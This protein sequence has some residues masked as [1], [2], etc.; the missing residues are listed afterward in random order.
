MRKLFLIFVAGLALL[1]QTAP[2]PPSKHERDLQFEAKKAAPAKATVAPVIPHSYAL[3]VGIAQYQNLPAAAQLKYPERDAEAIYSILISPEGGNF[4]AEN[5]HILSGPKATLA[6]VRKEL[7]EWL[8]SVTKDDDRVLIYFAGH[9]FVK[10][11][12]AY[13]APYDIKPDD[14]PATGYPMDQLGEVF[15]TQIKGKWKVL[16]TDACHSGAITP[17]DDNAVLSR[18]L[19]D[20]NKSVFS[21]SASRD[22]ERSYESDQWGS[23][24]GIFTY[25]V[26]RGLEGYA[27][28]S[29]DGV[30][31][32]DELAE[33]VRRNVREA[34]NG[35]QNPTSDRGSFDSDMLLAYLPSGVS[36]GAPPPAKFGTLVIEANMDG[37]EVFVNG[38]SVGVVDKGKPLSLPGLTPGA[39]TIKAVKMGY[40]PD[41][42][43]EE[44]IYPGQETTVSVKIVIPR[45]RQKAAVDKFDHGMELYNKG[46]PDAYKKAVEEFQAAFHED[47]TYSQAALYL[48]RV[49]QA[50]Y[51]L[52]NARQWAKKAI[53]IDPDYMDARAAYGGILLDVGDYDEAIRQLNLVTHRD[54]KNQVALYLQARTYFMKE[55]YA[56]S[57]D[58]SQAAIALAPNNGEAHLWLAESLRHLKQF[59]DSSREY[60]RYLELSNFDPTAAGKTGYVVGL[61]LIGVGTKKRAAQR[62]VWKEQRY[63]ANFGLCEN[64]KNLGRYEEAIGHCREALRYDPEDAFTFYELGLAYEFQARETGALELLAAARTSFSKMLNLNSDLAE[65]ELAR[66]NIANI[67]AYLR[68]NR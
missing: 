8:P 38:K 42:P 19:L 16:L 18:H 27:D 37:V 21:L 63:I 48:A 40:E 26:V 17:V 20:L 56:Q 65:S 52:D 15:G 36:P 7:E 67:D 51:D 14:I 24:H 55:M 59:D 46:T 4:K 9:G 54:P 29:G 53:E 62:D 60:K 34:T 13:L 31:T 41:G 33:Y 47:A 58:S 64:A 12:R 39:V 25:Y 11:G 32:A 68:D 3:V 10:S 22:R 2:A 1:A 23:G 49:Y 28:E 50:L 5:V 45:R 66:K 6:S 30:V 35:G 61:A 44:M 57:V 43:R